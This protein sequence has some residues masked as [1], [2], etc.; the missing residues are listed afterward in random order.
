MDQ[1]FPPVLPI[2]IAV[3]SLGLLPFAVV[4]GTAFTKISIVLML[5]RNAIGVQQAPSGI[6]INSIALSL[7]LF[8]MV[9]VGE[10]ILSSFQEAKYGLN[11]WDSAVSFFHIVSKSFEGYL[12][13]VTS[14]RE[15][16][17]FLDA[18]MKIWPPSLHD[19]VNRANLFILLPAHVT[20]EITKAFE[21]SFLIFLPFVIVDLVV[22]NVLLAMGAMMVPPMLISLPIKIL[23]FVAIDGWAIL[24]HNLLLSYAY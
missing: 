5:L 7:T 23:F 13:R 8:I 15:L 17:F 14:E 16:S 21:I 3:M 10:E 12:T 22:S 11:D 18:A 9:P 1:T 19:Y 20:S 2:V 4:M 6:V 24:L